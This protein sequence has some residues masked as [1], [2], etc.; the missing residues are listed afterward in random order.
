MKF[1]LRAEFVQ[2]LDLPFE[3]EADSLKEAQDL[4][5]EEVLFGKTDVLK[6][7]GECAGNH[8]HRWE[9]S[10]HENKMFCHYCGLLEEDYKAIEL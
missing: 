6:I 9:L 2:N 3:I 1:V 7:G 5:I 10:P 8:G 4:I